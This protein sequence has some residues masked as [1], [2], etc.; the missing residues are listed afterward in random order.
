MKVVILAGGLGTRLAEET[1]SRP[2][3]MVEIGG[4]PIIWHIMKIYSHFGFK[5]FIVC[6][7]YKGYMIKEFFINYSYHASDLCVN[8]INNSVEIFDLKSEPWE[9]KLIDTG[10]DTQTGGRLKRLSHLLENEESFCMTYGDGL[11]DIN[12]KSLVDS[13]QKGGRLATV[14]A[15]RPPARFG[16]LEFS[17]DGRVQSFEEKPDGDGGWINGGFF[18]MS[19]DCLDIISDD[20]TQW[21]GDPLRELCKRGELGVYQHNGFWRPMD[22]LRDKISLSQLWD[23][24]LA[25]WKIWQ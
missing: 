23:S 19:P 10:L 25:P 11:A 17:G 22:T 4:M 1:E 5:D 16:A 14:T 21:E 7:G 18:V 20:K 3:P 12:I 13:H 24:G 6:C 15:V 8:L 2:K 9:I